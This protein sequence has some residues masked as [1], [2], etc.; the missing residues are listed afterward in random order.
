MAGIINQASSS[1]DWEPSQVLCTFWS[2]NPLGAILVAFPPLSA[3]PSTLQVEQKRL[4]SHSPNQKD[5]QKFFHRMEN[6]KDHGVTL[7]E[8]CH[9]LVHWVPK[10]PRGDGAWL[11]RQRA[12][13]IKLPSKPTPKQITDHGSIPAIIQRP[14]MAHQSEHAWVAEDDAKEGGYV[15][16]WA[17]GKSVTFRANGHI[18]QLQHAL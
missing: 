16:S 13:E 8:K 7:R 4:K 18:I 17:E 5:H 12:D 11:I 15:T 9:H 14:L 1:S 10:I 6:E 2:L 3:G